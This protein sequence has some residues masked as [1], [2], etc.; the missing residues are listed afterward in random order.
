MA[1]VCEQKSTPKLKVTDSLLRKSNKNGFGNEVG[2]ITNRVTTMYDVLA[3]LNKDSKEYKELMRRIMCGQAL[4][5][6]EIDKIKG[7]QAKSMPKEWYD[8]KVNKIKDDDS[9]SIRELKEINLKL[10]VNKKPYFFIYNYD[11]LHLKY[12]KF[13]KSV[14]NNV[15]IRFGKTLDELYS[16]K[17]KTEDELSFL[18]SIKY[19]SPVFTNPSAMNRICWKIENEFKDVKLKINKDGDNFKYSLYKTDKRYSNSVYLEIEKLFKEYK[20]SQKQYFQTK[21]NRMKS[22]DK[23]EQ[24]KIFINNF[25]NKASEL[26]PNGE[27]LC[28]MIIDLVYKTKNNRQFAWDICGE[29]IIENLLNKNNGKYTIPI[30]DDNGDIEWN[31]MNF[32]MEEI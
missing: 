11:N 7:I 16:D 31:G 14:K 17:N 20:S 12:T 28:N 1:I 15:L 22:E 13:M 8:Y 27:D 21:R 10:I 2:T 6:E 32:R 30:Q 25:R 9:L 29:Q 24:R 26:S 4:Q 3:S 18:Q 23:S 5:Q 19:K